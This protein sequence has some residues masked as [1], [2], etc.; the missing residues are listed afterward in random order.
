MLRH[1]Y[2]FRGLVTACSRDS[3]GRRTYMGKTGFHALV[4]QLS[5]LATLDRWVPLYDRRLDY[6]YW[7]KKKL[8]KDVRLVKVSHETHLYLNSGGNIEGVFVEYLK[9]NFAEHNSD[10]KKM[11][12]IFD[13]KIDS[14]EYTI[15]NKNRETVFLFDK[16]AESL[17]SDIYRDATVDKYRVDEI[18]LAISQALAS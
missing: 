5:S 4:D 17:K 8:S 9:N 13:K 14:N 7:K 16:F 11:V 1:R 2:G 3:S 6:F 12:R 15:S 18:N 10:Y